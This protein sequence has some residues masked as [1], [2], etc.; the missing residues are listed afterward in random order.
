MNCSMPFEKAKIIENFTMDD[1][2][3]DNRK[4]K[5]RTVS[6]K[7]RILSNHGSGQTQSTENSAHR[8]A[9][10]TEDN[11]DKLIN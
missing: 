1:F 11:S 9:L 4:D 8:Y 2:E 6:Q 3:F 7:Q 10:L 5:S